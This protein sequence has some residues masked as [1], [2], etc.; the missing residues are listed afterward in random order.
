METTVSSYVLGLVQYLF[1]QLGKT[2]STEELPLLRTWYRF[3]STETH[4]RGG[5]QK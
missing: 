2:P 5:R 1:R 4:V 3:L